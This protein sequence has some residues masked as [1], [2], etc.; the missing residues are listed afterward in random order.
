[1]AATMEDLKR[2]LSIT[3]GAGS[4]VLLCCTERYMSAF[5]HDPVYTVRQLGFLKTVFN[6]IKASE[7]AMEIL[8]TVGEPL[9]IDR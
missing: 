5:V 9:A 6:S 2:D 3:D 1:M 7:R 8:R 4:S